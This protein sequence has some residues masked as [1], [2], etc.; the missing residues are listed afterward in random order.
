MVFPK[1]FRKPK[2]PSVKPKIPKKT[3]EN[4]KNIR[5]NQKNKVFKGFRP[6]LGYGFGLFGFLVFPKVFRK[7]KKPS[8]KPK[9]P[10]K[11][12]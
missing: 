7:P 3:K 9:I 6:T 8:V 4:Q 1:V 10:K 5:K 11:T 12:K 2:K